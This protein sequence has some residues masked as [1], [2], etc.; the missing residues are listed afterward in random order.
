MPVHRHI[1][2]WNLLRCTL[3]SVVLASHEVDR[4]YRRG[5]RPLQSSVRVEKC[6]EIGAVASAG[7]F[8]AGALGWYLKPW[9]EEVDA[10]G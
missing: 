8:E 6:K 9:S 7:V 5:G 2:L 1:L 3:A 4:I 10:S